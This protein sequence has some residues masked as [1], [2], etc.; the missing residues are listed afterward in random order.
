MLAEAISALQIEPD[1]WYIDTTFG[2]GGHTQEILKA[3]GKVA[4]FDCD[5]EAVE[6]GGKTFKTEIKKGQLV[7]IREN[8]DK[9]EEVIT[10]LQK[11]KQVGKIHG[12]LFDFGTSVDQLKNPARGFSFDTNSPLDMRMDH[13]LGV[14]GYD[15]LFLL[16]EKQLTQVLR[17]Y[18]GE[19]YA[20]P[21][22]KAIAE[23]KNENQKP[24]ET[25]KQLADLVTKVKRGRTGKLH[26]ATKTFQALR[27]AVNFELDAINQSLPQA[28]Q[29]L[30]KGGKMVTIAFHEGEDRAVKLFFKKLK[31]EHRAEIITPKP[32]QPSSKEVTQ[33]PKSRSAKL[34]VLRKL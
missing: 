20:K 7:L 33:N 11:K 24:P 2:R 12:I 23:Y 8:F 30:N 18:G 16:S 29:V 21:I 1:K 22:A 32:L 34:R 26:P 15:M 25:T 3:G 13:R 27:I 9:L 17:D 4:A 10:N 31:S 5:H 14:T 19:T 28:F 6:Y